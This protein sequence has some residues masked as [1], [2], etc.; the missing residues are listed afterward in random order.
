MEHSWK[1]QFHRCR[2]VLHP[3]T[4]T[5]PIESQQKFHNQGKKIHFTNYL[6]WWIHIIAVQGSCRWRSGTRCRSRCGNSCD[7]RNW[8]WKWGTGCAWCWRC[9]TWIGT[10]INFTRRIAISRITPPMAVI[11][12]VHHFPCKNQ[13]E[14]KGLANK[15][16][17]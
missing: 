5:G 16:E 9:G 10:G 11:D 3:N 12:I 8:A 7:K 13:S 2:V 17:R 6:S 1:I 4:N 15:T 14:D